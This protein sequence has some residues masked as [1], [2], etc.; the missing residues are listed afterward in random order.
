MLSLVQRCLNF[1][2]KIIGTHFLQSESKQERDDM[3]YRVMSVFLKKN[4]EWSLCQ[5]TNRDDIWGYPNQT[6]IIFLFTYC[7]KS[8]FQK[9]SSLVEHPHVLGEHGC[10]G[11]HHVYHRCPHHPIHSLQRNMGLW[12]KLLSPSSIISGDLT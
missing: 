9:Q 8:S 11:H 3:G 6:F 4:M 10:V 2:L 1:E 7:I 5:S 12:R